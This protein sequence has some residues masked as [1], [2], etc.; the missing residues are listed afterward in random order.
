ML[1]YFPWLCHFFSKVV[2]PCCTVEYVE[3]QLAQVWN[4]IAWYRVGTPIW[5]YSFVWKSISSYIQSG[6]IERLIWNNYSTY[7]AIFLDI[8]CDLYTSSMLSDLHTNLSHEVRHSC[9][10]GKPFLLHL[11]YPWPRHQWSQ[12]FLFCMCASPVCLLEHFLDLNFILLNFKLS[13][14]HYFSH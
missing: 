14:G 8:T 5:K 6:I 9:N 10:V 11:Y 13:A 3:K 7:K 12:R 4:V 2:H 1:L